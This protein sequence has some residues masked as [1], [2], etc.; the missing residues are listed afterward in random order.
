VAK[1]NFVEF[2]SGKKY[3]K[4]DIWWNFHVGKYV[5]FQVKNVITIEPLCNGIEKTENLPIKSR[6]PLYRDLAI[7]LFYWDF[8]IGKK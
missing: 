4:C 5:L 8:Q 7:N 6:L 2:L 3:L 1:S